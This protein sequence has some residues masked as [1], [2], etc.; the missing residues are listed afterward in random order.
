MAQQYYGSKVWLKCSSKRPASQ[1]NTCNKLVNNRRSL[2][3]AAPG[4]MPHLHSLLFLWK[5]RDEG[6]AP[7][8]SCS[9]LK[10]DPATLFTLNTGARPA[11][12]N[13]VTW[14][15]RT[16]KQQLGIYNSSLPVQCLQCKLY[17]TTQGPAPFSII[18]TLWKH[19]MTI[20]AFMQ[21]PDSQIKAHKRPAESLL[22]VELFIHYT[23]LKKK[24]SVGPGKL[25]AFFHCPCFH[26]KTTI[27]DKNVSVHIQD[28][29]MLYI[30]AFTTWNSKGGTFFWKLKAKFFF[31][32]QQTLAQQFGQRY[33]FSFRIYLFI[34]LNLKK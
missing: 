22:T 23:R 4:C 14:P 20:Q 12:V 19:N 27:G 5:K 16:N 33:G 30:S 17:C 11:R 18:H 26:C 2:I 29:K 1:K 21:T 32:K 9:L 15:H 28:W 31:T 24:S 7:R 34:I 25:A 8:P 3:P 13:P 10:V 6:R